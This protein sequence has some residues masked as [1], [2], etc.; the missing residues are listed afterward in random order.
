MYKRIFGAK[1]GN[2]S[3]ITERNIL[4][5]AADTA[6]HTGQ[7]V[8][9]AATFNP[10]PSDASARTITRTSTNHAHATQTTPGSNANTHGLIHAQKKPPGSHPPDWR[11]PVVV[12]VSKV[13]YWVSW[14]TWLAALFY[15]ASIL[16]DAYAGRNPND[17]VQDFGEFF[18]VYLQSLP[19]SPHAS[20]SHVSSPAVN[21]APSVSL[22]SD[23]AILTN[24]R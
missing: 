20:H 24:K 22:N 9:N 23:T 14:I 12:T 10:L 8:F 16:A 2:N 3:C 13:L 1:S 17:I 6:P 19:A 7:A 18:R 11:Q 4:Q 15:L 21:S 5:P